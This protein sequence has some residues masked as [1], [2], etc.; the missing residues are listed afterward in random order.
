MRRITSNPGAYTAPH[1]E[2]DMDSL[3]NAAPGKPGYVCAPPTMSRSYVVWDRH[4]GKPANRT[5]Y[6]S[7]RAALRAVDRLDL[8][9]GACRYFHKPI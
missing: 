6:R 2:T 9:Y 7:L 5:V 4:T 3:H 8:A 1:L